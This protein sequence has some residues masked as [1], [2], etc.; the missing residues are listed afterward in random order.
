MAIAI[1][2]GLFIC[3]GGFLLFYRTDIIFSAIAV[4]VLLLLTTA[5]LLVF[6]LTSVHGVKNIEEQEE[7]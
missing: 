7:T 5:N 6:I 3:L 1:G 4:I 2:I